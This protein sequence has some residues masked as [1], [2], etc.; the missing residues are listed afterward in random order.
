MGIPSYFKHILDRY[1][2]L[3]TEPGKKA[4]VLLM[5]FNC[6]IYGCIHAKTLPPYSHDTREAWETAVLKEICAYVVHIWTVAGKP[7]QVLLAVDGVVPMAKI[8]QQRLRRFKS[9]WLAGKE[10]EYGVRPATQEVWDTNAITPGTEFMERLTV[11]LE[12]LCKSKGAGWIVS[13]AEV[14]GEGEQK[15]M[16]W[17]RSRGTSALEGKHIVVYGLDADL[18]LLCMLH[19]TCGAWSILR[20]KQEFIK[21]ATGGSGPQFL[22]LS[23]SGLKDILFPDPALRTRHM[24]DYI[25]GM[26]LLGNDFIPHSLGVHLRDAGHDRLL[27]VLGDLHAEGTFLVSAEGRPQWNRV[28]L[29]GPPQWNHAALQKIFAVWASTEEADLEHAFKRKYTTRGPP[30]RTSAEQCMLPVQNLPLEYAEESRMWNRATGKLSSDWASRYY[31]EKRD[32][33]LTAVEIGERCTEYCRGLQWALDYYTGQE[34]I[35]EEWMYPWTYPPLWSDLLAFLGKNPMPV[36]PLAGTRRI[37]PQ[38]QLT[39][40]L[41]LESWRLIRQPALRLLPSVA[42]HFWPRSFGFTTLGK[43][44]MWECPPDIPILTFRRL[45][46]D[47]W[48]QTAGFTLQ[49]HDY[50]ESIG[51]VTGLP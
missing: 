1:P 25:A 13:G 12:A 35:S 3:L 18:I 47:G 31:L 36:V 20:E 46:S 14:P 6:L 16:Q 4:D 33:G 2:K 43:R 29:Q 22:L 50:R 41:P 9:V 10:R 7:E 15:L 27:A 19:A 44:W 45:I 51:R 26:S 39:L 8:R 37:Q 28:A 5:D 34:A 40:V 11:H 48:F 32:R 24:Y 17:V 23:V 38:E 42:P 21:K 30:A 49:E